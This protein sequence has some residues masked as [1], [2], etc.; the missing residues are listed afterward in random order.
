M[1]EFNN[2]ISLLKSNQ[3]IP[4]EF[5]SLDGYCKAVKIIHINSGKLFFIQV[6]KKYKIIIPDDILNKYTITKDDST[7]K[8]FNSSYL[9]DYYPM[10]KIDTK[11]NQIID[12]ISSVLK[13]NYKQQIVLSKNSSFE[14]LEQLKRIKYCF[15][16]L[17]YKIILQTT[18]HLLFLTYDN[19]IEVYEVHYYVTNKSLKTFY[20]ILTLE[21]F[22]LKIKLAYKFIIEIDNELYN[23]L[24]M[25][26]SKHN[27]HMTSQ[28][29]N[30]FI[31]NNNKLLEIK[32]NL[33]KTQSEISYLLN[34]IQEKEEK[35]LDE[36]EEIISRKSTNIYDEA[37]TS[38]LKEEIEKKYNKIHSIK[39]KLIDKNIS[40][41][42]KIKNI[43][44]V[45]DQLGFNLSVSLNELRNEL[46]IIME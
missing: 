35:I 34:D 4:I 39:L 16:T 30:N 32:Y 8:E 44:L 27:E 28:F 19:N 13:S 1:S 20:P 11:E 33:L 7:T 17:E 22:Y 37:N 40:L 15:K 45:I 46:N 26:Q 2:F 18:T 23:I 41:D 31:N 36:R 12:N 14:H 3:Y 43:Y 42:N 21:Q 9:S 5:F 10:I 6:S 24:N 25:N 29:V 38:K